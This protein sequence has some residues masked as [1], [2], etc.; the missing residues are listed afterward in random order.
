[1]KKISAIDALYDVD[2]DKLKIRMD[3]ATIQKT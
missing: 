2:K 1:M 3:N